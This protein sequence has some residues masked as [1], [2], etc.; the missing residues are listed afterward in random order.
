LLVIVIH[1]HERHPTAAISRLVNYKL[2]FLQRFAAYLLDLLKLT[3]PRETC[4]TISAVLIFL[5]NQRIIV[6]FDDNYDDDLTKED[7]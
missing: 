5:Y 3:S 1:K 6:S 7:G 4:V 2:L